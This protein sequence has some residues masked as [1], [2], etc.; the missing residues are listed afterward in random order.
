MDAK[1]QAVRAAL[2]ALS[3]AV[4]LNNG[5]TGP[6]PAPAA[7]AMAAALQEELTGGRTGEA[8]FRRTFGLAQELRQLLAAVLD[9]G[10]DAIALTGS[11]TEGVNIALWSLD[12]QPGDEVVS[13]NTEHPGVLFPLFSLRDRR[14]VTVRLADLLEPGQD[15]VAALERLI[16]PRTRLVA[17]SHVAWSTGELYP[18]EEIAAMC[19][20]HRVL[21]LV[22]GA[23]AAGVVPLR[24]RECGADFYALPGQKWLLGPEGTGALYVRAERLPEVRNTFAGYVSA[25]AWHRSGFLPHPGAR[26]FEYGLRHPVSLVGLLAAVRWL[27]DEVGLP[28]AMERS[29]ALAARLRRHLQAIP[30]VRVITPER[31]AA[32]V[33]FQIP[34]VRPEEAVRA[35]E[36]RGFW[37]RSIDLPPAVRA[38]CGFYNTEEEIDG[39]A[40]AVA[41][42]ARGRG[43]R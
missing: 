10:P 7:E 3:R 27:R 6:L 37:V 33:S 40:E 18:V 19:R 16:T 20:A 29:H 8:Y 12:W 21:L 31:H 5:T 11:T 30:G 22:D 14:G 34:G 41:D 42:I 4:Y 13:A 39:L 32:L 26:R 23:Q 2:P 28:W 9:A 36:E 24:L 1:L 17:I 15:V 38:S 43:Q 35:L 25:Q